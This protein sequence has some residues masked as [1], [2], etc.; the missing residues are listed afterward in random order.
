MFRKIFLFA[1]IIFCPGWSLLVAQNVLR[2]PAG[3]THNLKGEYHAI[4]TLYLGAGAT[5]ALDQP[6]VR[7]LIE[8][9]YLE[10]DATIDGRGEPGVDGKDGQRGRD[11]T[12]E[13]PAT[14]GEKGES[15]GSGGRGTNLD[16][17]VSFASVAGQL[18]IDLSGGSAGSGGNGG[19]GGDAYVF[20]GQY[21]RGTSGGDAGAAGSSGVP[22]NLRLIVTSELGRDSIVHQKRYGWLGEEGEAGQP[23]GFLPYNCNKDDGQPDLVYGQ[24]GE[25]SG[26]FPS[27]GPESN[28]PDDHLNF[29][30]FPE[31][32]PAASDRLANLPMGLPRGATFGD[33]YRRIMSALEYGRYR[34]PSVQRW[35]DGFALITQLEQIY[36]DGRPL[37]GR[38]R[39]S[40]SIKVAHSPSILSYLKSLIFARRGYFRVM[41][42][43]VG[44]R[45]GLL[46]TS[47]PVS[48]EEAL[49]WFKTSVGELPSDLQSKSFGPD[50]RVSVLVY[51]F[52]KRENYEEAYITEPVR[53]P[54]TDH[55]ER[56]YLLERLRKSE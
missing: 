22:G 56:S 8:V 3:E 4:D 25:V 6:T 20:C 39:W 28:L 11:G 45:D 50:H 23:G 37:D 7:L 35:R 44:K 24:P 5:L 9:A 10:G 18:T 36:P 51:E 41:V 14:N 40:Q 42:F 29:G 17:Y 46:T 33:V 53:L 47:R 26:S 12:A 21:I 32:P 19:D 31:N 55:L 49:A 48:R 27:I 43:L 16:L 34:P 30:T 38:E 15:G 54:V 52:V 2:V 13:T 1:A